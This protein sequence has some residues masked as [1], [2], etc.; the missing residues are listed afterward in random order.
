VTPVSLSCRGNDFEEKN[1]NVVYNYHF[2]LEF[3]D[4][5]VTLDVTP[6]MMTVPPGVHFRD[7]ENFRQRQLQHRNIET[8]MMFK[9]KMFPIVPIRSRIKSSVVLIEKSFIRTHSWLYN[10][11][12]NHPCYAKSDMSSSLHCACE[13]MTLENI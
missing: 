6:V 3:D 13:G 4:G 10:S 8:E 1:Q 5:A 12:T 11:D 2:F 9:N 7:S